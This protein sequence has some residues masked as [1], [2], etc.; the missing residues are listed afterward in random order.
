[1]QISR[2]QKELQQSIRDPA[3]LLDR[4][5]LPV[6]DVPLANQSMHAF[7]IRIPPHYLSNIHKRDPGDPLLR[8]V[9]PL[10]DEDQ[11][12]AGYSADPLGELQQ[13]AAPGVLHKY[14]G[15][16]L[17]ITTGA[18]AIHCRYCFRR[19]FPYAENHIGNS[20][21]D[22]ALDY[23]RNDHSIT[24]VILSGGD[25]LM[26]TDD[27]LDQL[28]RQLHE[29]RHLRRLRIHSRIISVVPSRITNA[30]LDI[31][32][33]GNLQTVLV[34]HCNHPNE[35]DEQVGL[36]LSRIRATGITLL[37]QSVLLRGV[38]DDVGV[39]IALV[40]RLFQYGVLPYYLHVLDKVAGAGHFDVAMTAARSLQEGLRRQLPGYLVPRLVQEFPGAPYKIP[41]L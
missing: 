19:H 17:L 18:C 15:R 32:T 8:Q 22:P 16:V 25:P 7:P 24:E 36:A 10:A 31:L 1:M 5:G 40:E 21:W 26:L 6:A 12:H 29:I 23:I 3:T 11:D 34:N 28:L 9:L 14:H 38:N 35:I 37:N 41:V 30:L 4:L 27:K 2:W 33:R 20:N 39:L 13:S